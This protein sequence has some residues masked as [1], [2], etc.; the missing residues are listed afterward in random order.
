LDQYSVDY[1]DRMVEALAY[2]Q[3]L[4]EAMKR[5]FAAAISVYLSGKKKPRGCFLLATALTE[6]LL[7]RDVRTAMAEGFVSSRRCSRRASASPRSGASLRIALILRPSPRLPRP[8]SIR[9]QSGRAP[10]KGGRGSAA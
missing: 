10:A 6:A 3:P 4:A 1:R 9:W 5:A 7:D 8:P 2:D